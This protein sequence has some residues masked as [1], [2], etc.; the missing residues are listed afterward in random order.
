MAKIGSQK[1]GAPTECP[2]FHLQAVAIGGSAA[3]YTSPRTSAS[4]A[5]RAPTTEIVL[6]S[7]RSPIVALPPNNPAQE[8]APG[9]ILILEPRVLRTH[10]RLLVRLCSRNMRHYQIFFCKTS[11]KSCGRIARNCFAI[12]ALRVTTGR[13]RG[14][15]FFPGLHSPLWST[16]RRWWPAK[17]LHPL[18]DR[19][20]APPEPCKAPTE[21]RSLAKPPP[22]PCSAQVPQEHPRSLPLIA[23]LACTPSPPGRRG[24]TLLPLPS[25]SNNFFKAFS[26]IPCRYNP[27]IRHSL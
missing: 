8:P 27:T 1:A 22:H 11:K 12:S 18:L 5:V 25:L 13:R 3:V 20:H 9:K 24:E 10:Y 14:L 23:S 19:S 26:T 4:E 16:L 6:A 7:T 21:V 15:R 2:T 17:L